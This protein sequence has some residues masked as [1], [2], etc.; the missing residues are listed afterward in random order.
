M[1]V[2]VFKWAVHTSMSRR[3]VTQSHRRRSM[4]ACASKS[5]LSALSMAAL[6]STA[7]PN[8]PRSLG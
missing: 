1:V 8:S 4:P 5:W 6:V 2:R 3:V 7:L